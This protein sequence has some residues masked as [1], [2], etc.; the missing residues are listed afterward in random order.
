MVTDGQSDAAI[1]G[2]LVAEFGKRILALPEGAT[3]LW[4]FW[5]PMVSLGLGLLALLLFLKRMRRPTVATALD[6]AHVA[7]L[8]AA[9][10][11]D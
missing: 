8:D 1:K 4:L 2:A 5:T 7:E 11:R 10:D 6:A 3:R 9:W